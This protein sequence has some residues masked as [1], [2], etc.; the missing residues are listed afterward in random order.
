MSLKRK[1]CSSGVWKASSIFFL[2]YTILHAVSGNAAAHGV[3][4]QA[5]CAHSHSNCCHWCSGKVGQHELSKCSLQTLM[6]WKCWQCCHE[7]TPNVNSL[8][9]KS[10]HVGNSVQHISQEP[11][12]R[13]FLNLVNHQNVSRERKPEVNSGE[14]FY[15]KV[16][17]EKE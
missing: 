5:A 13:W 16:M 15:S 11:S 2:C 17:Q 4:N 12:Q 7:R 6:F 14:G 3:H 8:K 9:G 1:W 10:P